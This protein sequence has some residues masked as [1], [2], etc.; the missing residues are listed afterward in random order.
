MPERA[1]MALS[2]PTAAT[3][4]DQRHFSDPEGRWQLLYALAKTQWF[5]FKLTWMDWAH[6]NKPVA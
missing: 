2:V 3:P 5:V 4:I 6:S 1:A